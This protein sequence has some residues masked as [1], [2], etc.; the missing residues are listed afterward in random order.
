MA[1]FVLFGVAAPDKAA[2]VFQDIHAFITEYVGWLY[3]LT[4]SIFLVFLIWL[5]FSRGTPPG[6]CRRSRIAN[7]TFNSVSKVIH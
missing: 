7:K 5:G 6:R 4:V 2:S 1:A 3:L